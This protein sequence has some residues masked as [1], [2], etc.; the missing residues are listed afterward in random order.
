MSDEG[1][2]V[3]EEA[4]IVAAGLPRPVVES[5][6]RALQGAGDQ[7]PAYVRQLALQV[8]PQP[9]FRALIGHFV[10]AWQQHAPHVRAEA[11]ALALLAA[12]DA[13]E[14]CRRELSVDLVWTGP[15]VADIPLRRTDQALLQ[16]IDA[17]QRSLLIVSFAVYRIPAV[18]QAIVRAAGRGVA[19][20][21]CLEAPE[22][23]GQRMGYDTVQALGP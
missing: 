21:I 2:R 22:P 12:A 6:A 1:A 3:A 18:A 7:D 20:T 5:L 13:T 17:A 19:V 4:A 11:A 14:H 23:S 16:V 8:T 15:D 10:D 9:H